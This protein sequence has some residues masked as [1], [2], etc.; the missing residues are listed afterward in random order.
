MPPSSSPWT[1][2]RSSPSSSPRPRTAIHDRSFHYGDV[3]DALA[4]R[5]T[6][7]C[8][9][10]FRVPRFTCLPVECYGVVCDWDE[11]GGTAHRVGEL[12]G[13][14]HAAR[15]RGRGARPAGDRLRLLTPPD[16]GGS[17]GV[18]AAILPYVVLVGLAARALGVP[19]RWT[20]DR[21]E[22]LAASSAATGRVTE[23][24]GG[25]HGR[26]ASSSRCATTRSRTSART[27]ALPSRPRST[28][29]TARCPAPTASG[30]SPPGTAS[31]SRTRSR[32]A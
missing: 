20:E 4:G 17:F 28:A 10:R 29:C 1:T 22:H 8:A 14:V 9:R 7:W 16:S 3:D 21:L 5:R 25:L 13:A 30:T 11:P 15:G 31:C 24:G 2:S 26:R 32:R 12:P 23:A 18:K 27:C 6:S 19:V